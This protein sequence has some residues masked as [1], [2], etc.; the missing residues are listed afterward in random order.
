[1]ITLVLKG[2]VAF[3]LSFIVLSFQINQKTIF[4]HMTELL[5]PLGEDVQRSLTKS[6]KRGFKKSKNIGSDFFENAEPRYID[7][8]TSERSSEI[9]KKG[10]ET[11]LEEI[12]REER[13][14]LDELIKNDA[15]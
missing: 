1:M 7:K 2:S 13:Q 12:K 9:L 4:I 10:K 6:V 14:K 11:I 8:V 3:L 5:G 15:L